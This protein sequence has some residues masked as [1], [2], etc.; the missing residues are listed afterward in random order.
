MKLAKF[1][2]LFVIMLDVMGQGLILPIITA[3]LLDS[4]ETMLS[5]D[6]TSGRRQLYFG[7]T[8]GVFFLSWFFGAA[9][10][11]KLSDFIGRKLGIL[12]CLSGG[13]I[14]YILTIISLNIDSFTLLLV[15]RAI[16]GFTLG[17][18]PIA[19]AALID[20]CKNDAEKNREM[21]LAVVAISLG[22][23]IGPL[24][25]GFLS[26]KSILGDFASLQLPFY[27]GGGLVLLSIAMILIFFHN[28]NFT[29]RPIKVKITDVFLTLWDAS[30]R[31]I[32]RKL[33]YVFFCSQ[34]AINTFFVF[35]NDYLKTKF[36]FDTLQNSIIL[37]IF[38]IATSIASTVLVARLVKRF[39]QKRII[40]G[41]L[42]V[43]AIGLI[44]FMANPFGGLAYAALIPFVVGWAVNY[45][46]MLTL[47]SASVDEMEQG[48]V[49]G[50]TVALY[51]LGG[52]IISIVAGQLMAINT[53]LPFSIATG[54]VVIAFVLILSLWR[55]EAFEKLGS[56]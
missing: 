23:V 1:S 42:V 47:F 3:V 13:L 49:M 22:V 46:I 31:P 53:Y 21:S 56:R 36:N 8:M 55:G 32:V 28:V 19:Q 20:S 34:I 43:M 9:Y 5:A 39:P 29:R 50:V 15:A 26:S 54:A 18:Q 44:A 24:L 30:K 14:G 37:I 16:T 2:L 11:S 45:P 10:I 40:Y 25:G 41:T 51:T 6:T 17:N 48:W 35:V 52:G 33:S 12:I 38:G 7:I 27:A 4:N